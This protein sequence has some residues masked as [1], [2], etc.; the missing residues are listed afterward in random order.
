MNAEIS[1][2]KLQSASLVHPI[3]EPELTY[4]F[5]HVLI[6]ETAYG[7]LL[8]KGRRQ[9]HLLVAAAFEHEYGDRLDEFAPDLAY[10]YWRGE[11]WRRAAEYA[12][13]A[14][15]R[16][17]RVYGLRE[18]I[19][20]YAQA[21]AALD[22][23][24]NAPGE[25]ICDVILGW[26]EA[27]FAFEPYAKQLDLLARAERLVRQFGD[28]RRLALILHSIGKVH[29]ASGYPNRATAPLIE[30]FALATELGDEALAVIPTFYMGVANFDSDPRRAVTWFDRAIALARTHGDIDTEAYAL[31]FKAMVEARL[32]ETASSRQD[33]D[34]ALELVPQ[35]KSPMCDSDVHLYS[36]WAWLDLGDVSR[37]LEY[38]KLAVDKSVSADNMECACI[39]FACLGFL[40]LRADQIADAVHAFEE[41]IRRSKFSGSL[42]SQLLGEMGLGMIRFFAG[43]PQAVEE[44]ESARERAKS[45]G[46]EYISALIALTLGEIY[47]HR[48]ATELA[49]NY[50]NDALGYYRRHLMRPY[51]TRA[52]DLL[53]QAYEQQGDQAQASAA[54]QELSS[55]TPVA[56]QPT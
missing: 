52:L 6:Q 54:R 12:R 43:H 38:A 28:K 51:L 55:I 34:Q 50:L 7:S 8:V 48:G 31:G 47:L 46:E 25:E 41:A 2:D 32:G 3:A 53:A 26:A 16:A 45:A 22:R 11:D 13:R 35:I 39:A 30:C 24:P 21:L 29:V 4:L 17:L 33:M 44:L 1:L 19:G 36:A 20:D 23:I 42:P 18:A 10:H 37:G 15:D 56:A 49:E 40:Q 9:F 14:G 27:A 5:N